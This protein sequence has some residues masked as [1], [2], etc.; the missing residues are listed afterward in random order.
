MHALNPLE[1]VLGIGDRDARMSSGAMRAIAA[2]G[3]GVVV[4]LRDLTM[5]IVGAVRSLAADAAPI[6]A[7]RADPVALGLHDLILLTNSPQPKVV[8]LDAYGLTI[9][10][11]RPISGVRHGRSTRDPMAHCRCRRFDKPVRLL[12]VVA[13]LLP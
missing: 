11:T 10:G 2:E 1:D 9:A 8:G 3:R 6:R 4:L 7:R 12:I 5:K 13:P